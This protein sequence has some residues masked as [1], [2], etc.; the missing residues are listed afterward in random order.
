MRV[1]AEYP[2]HHRSNQ[3]GIGCKASSEN[4]VCPAAPSISHL[5]PLSDARF[6]VRYTYDASSFMPAVL[7][8]GSRLQFEISKNGGET[9]DAAGQVTSLAA[10]CALHVTQHSS[11][12]ELL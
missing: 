6:Q 10:T 2:E 9:W 11:V 4:K 7:Q 3:N 8:G 1:D 12:Y 5:S